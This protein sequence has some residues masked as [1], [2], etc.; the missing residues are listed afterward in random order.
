MFK[1]ILN[2]AFGERCSR[3]LCLE[4]LWFWF[5]LRSG[6]ILGLLALLFFFCAGIAQQQAQVYHCIWMLGAGWKLATN[7]AILYFIFYAIAF[8]F[9]ILR[10]YRSNYMYDV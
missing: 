5:S 3:D 4:F 7:N 1:G 9:S 2:I 6:N 8:K 10:S